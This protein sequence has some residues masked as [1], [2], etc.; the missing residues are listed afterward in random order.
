MVAGTSPSST[1][2]SRSVGPVDIRIP[3]NA[4]PSRHS[5]VPNTMTSYGAVSTELSRTETTYFSALDDNDLARSPMSFRPRSFRETIGSLAES[6]SRTSVLY[7]AENLAVPASMSDRIYSHHGTSTSE[8]IADEECRPLALHRQEEDDSKPTEMQQTN[9]DLFLSG[10]DRTLS[11]RTAPPT[12]RSS[13]HLG[14][15]PLSRHATIASVIS[16][17]LGLPDENEHSIELTM[18]SQKSSFTQSVFNAINVLIGVGILAFPL[19]FRYAGW[20]IGSFVFFFCALTT[21]YTAKLLV[22]CLD[23]APGAMTYGD[24]GMVGFGERGRALI[25]T[26]F[27]VEVMTMSYVRTYAY[28]KRI[29]DGKL[30]RKQSLDF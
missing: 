19:A 15:V 11:Q 29:T 9:L 30:K 3:N 5:E 13:N 25:G 1:G 14:F 10:L 17:Q 7:I 26:I 23:A 8:P 4:H 27:I 20:L 16:Q 6:Y 18:T 24:I 2:Y 28:A 21:N 12:T 22:R